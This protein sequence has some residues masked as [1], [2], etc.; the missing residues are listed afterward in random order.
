[1]KSFLGVDYGRARIGLAI[2][3]AGLIARPLKTIENKGERKNLAAFAA[4]LAQFNVGCIVIGLP[5]HKNSAMS[6][7]VR[8]FAETLEPLGVEIVFQNEMLSSVGA[9]GISPTPSRFQRATPSFRRGIN[10]IDSVAASVILQ[11]YL[12]KEGR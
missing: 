7:E 3:E 12:E 1:M 2:S 4:V 11:D 8:A 10:S 5:V 6:D 9:E